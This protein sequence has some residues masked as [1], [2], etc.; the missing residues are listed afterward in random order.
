V[1]SCVT[2]SWPTR[3]HARRSR[4]YG[5]ARGVSSQAPELRERKIGITPFDCPCGSILD[6]KFGKGVS[7]LMAY[8][9]PKCPI[10]FQA[11]G[12]DCRLIVRA[13]E[14]VSVG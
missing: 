7:R 10:R 4:Y 13:E 9:I 6:R 2:S 11:S 14:A 5:A 8:G 3:C 12:E 1:I